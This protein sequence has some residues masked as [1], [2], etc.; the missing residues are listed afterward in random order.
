MKSK[1]N[2]IKLAKAI[3]QLEGGLADKLTFEDI[4]KKHNISDEELEKQIEIG[5]KVEM[6]HTND[7]NK[8]VEIARDHL[9]EDPQYYTHLTAM[10]EQYN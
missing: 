5:I 6:E 9:V 8:Y 2:L 4:A 3:D 7:I 10:E 1:I